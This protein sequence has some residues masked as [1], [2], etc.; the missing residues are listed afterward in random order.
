VLV[1]LGLWLL[2]LL[3]LGQGLLEEIWSVAKR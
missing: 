1:L 3:L 2:L